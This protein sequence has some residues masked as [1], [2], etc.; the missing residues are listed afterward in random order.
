MQVCTIEKIDSRITQTSLARRGFDIFQDHDQVESK[1]KIKREDWC[2]T[3]MSNWWELRQAYFWWY[4]PVFW[5][6]RKRWRSQKHQKFLPAFVEFDKFSFHATNCCQVSKKLE[7][8]HWRITCRM[9]RNLSEHHYTVGFHFISCK[10]DIHSSLIASSQSF[11]LIEKRVN[12]D[13]INVKASYL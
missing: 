8:L 10:N 3:W 1:R 5:N 11:A 2:E 12:K 7:M 4:K 13:R 6:V 9:D